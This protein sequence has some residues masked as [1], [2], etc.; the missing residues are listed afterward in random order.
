MSRMYSNISAE[1][2]C[3]V[4]G[5]NSFG[6]SIAATGEPGTWLLVGSVDSDRKNGRQAPTLSQG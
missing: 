6:L 1:R 3:P 2:R 4:M 5:L